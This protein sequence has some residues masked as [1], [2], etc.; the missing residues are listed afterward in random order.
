MEV[1][2]HCLVMLCG[3]REALGHVSQATLQVLGTRLEQAG[4]TLT[5]EAL[6]LSFTCPQCHVSIA[7]I[8]GESGLKHMEKLL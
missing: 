1:L 8:L 7:S 5:C 6:R 2:F 3:S 4:A